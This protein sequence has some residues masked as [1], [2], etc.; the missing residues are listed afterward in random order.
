MRW[1]FLLPL[2]LITLQAQQWV[3]IGHGPLQ[4]VRLN[5]KEIKA[6]FLG[7]KHY[8]QKRRLSP[9]NLPPEHPLRTKFEAKVLKMSRTKIHQYWIKQHYLGKRPPKVMA[10]IEAL[11]RYVEAV[12]GAVAY[13]PLSSIGKHPIY[14][15]YLP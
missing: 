1:L 12:D 2:F 7:K 3:I 5:A 10:S 15:W 4:D 14:I 13:V 6:I 9:L 8:V 11:I